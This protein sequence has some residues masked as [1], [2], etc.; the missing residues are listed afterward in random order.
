MAKKKVKCIRVEW[1]PKYGGGDYSGV[2]LFAYLPVEDIEDH[3]DHDAAV[4][5]IFERETGRNPVHIIH[6][7][8][9]VM[10]DQEG[11]E[12]EE[13]DSPAEISNLAQCLFAIKELQK[14]V[15]NLENVLMIRRSKYNHQRAW[16]QEHHRDTWHYC[17]PD[18]LNPVCGAPAIPGAPLVS[19]NP[20]YAHS[21]LQ[22]VQLVGHPSQEA[23]HAEQT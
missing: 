1:D 19:S 2:G 22:C 4:K 15:E 3:L 23:K 17:G 6:Y 5:E 16:I 11:N 13:E 9:D 12:W 14:R 10:Y 18:G 8:S 7:F 20:D 21:C